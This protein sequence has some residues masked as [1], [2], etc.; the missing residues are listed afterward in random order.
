MNEPETY[1]MVKK[2]SPKKI[3]YNAVIAAFGFLLI[4]LTY[5]VYAI[6]EK[7]ASLK[8]SDD[9]IEYVYEKVGDLINILDTREDMSVNYNPTESYDFKPADNELVAEPSEENEKSKVTKEELSKMKD[10]DKLKLVRDKLVDIYQ[11]STDRES[12]FTKLKQS[13]YDTKSMVET[14]YNDKKNIKYSGSVGPQAESTN[15]VD[16]L[17]KDLSGF[18]QVSKISD[19]NAKDVIGIDQ[20]PQ[21]LGYAEI[22]LE[23]GSISQC[24]WIIEDIQTITKQKELT[25]FNAKA[26]AYIEKYPNANA[27]MQKVKDLIDIIQNQQ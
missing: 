4:Y 19:K 17:K 14:W 1:E 13:F 15:I 26:Q 24:L 22:L 7:L 23:S 16:K 8:I 12:E 5:Q 6:S 3:L 11:Q 2:S 21:M 18:V 27:D 25:E 9:K 10:S 20:I